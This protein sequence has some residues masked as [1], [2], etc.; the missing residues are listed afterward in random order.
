MNRQVRLSRAMA[1]AVVMSFGAMT[2]G[3]RAVV[4][5]GIALDRAAVVAQSETAR[6]SDLPRASLLKLPRPPEPFPTLST[7]QIDRQLELYL[8]YLAQ[9]GRPDVLI[10]G[11]SRALQGIDP[12]ALQ[13][14]LAEAGYPRLKV[15]NFGING[16]TAQ[17][18]N[19]QLNRL[20]KPQQWPRVIV[21]ADG[22]RAFNS[23][24]PDRT[25]RNIQ[26]SQGFQQLQAGRTPQLVPY[27]NGMLH[28]DATIRDPRQLQGLNIV[29]QVFAPN[30]YFR[31]FPKIAGRFD[32][33]YIDFN[34]AGAQ[35][36]ATAALLLQTRR[37]R[38][39]LVFVN[40]PLTDIYLD[41][42]R[43]RR[44]RQFRRYK[45]RLAGQ[46]QLTFIDMAQQ[47]P[48]RYDYFADPSHLN[49]SGAQAVAKFLG[50]RLAVYFE[51]QLGVAKP[52][53]QLGD[54]R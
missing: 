24:R 21:W 6:Q 4:A 16:A 54:R 53:Y 32:G 14:A 13:I 38:I 20:L 49:Q 8:R 26:A 29:R 10:V 7:P 19:L 11:S 50:R 42:L 31:R 47:W 45:Q 12:V 18:V 23:G 5:P 28:D 41:R 2:I 51:R 36:Q 52:A 43:D 37:R 35:A 27:L 40:L 1:V 48:D 25:Y 34:L 22:V 3:A 33:D 46:G 30:Q 39:P 17:V 9:Y 44:E 15:F